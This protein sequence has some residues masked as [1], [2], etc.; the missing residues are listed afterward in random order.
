VEAVWG[1]PDG[2]LGRASAAVA[3]VVGVKRRSRER[4]NAKIERRVER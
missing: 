2:R 3:A 1:W 4:A